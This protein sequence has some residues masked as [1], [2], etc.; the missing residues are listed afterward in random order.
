M[1]I[2]VAG[3]SG[4][5]GNAVLRQLKNNSDVTVITA[6]SNELDLTNQMM[7]EN[8]FRSNLIDQVYLC[9]AKVGGI[10]ANSKF[11]ADFI[12]NNLMIQSNVIHSAHKN[13]VQKLLF[14]GSSCIY[15]KM[16]EQPIKEEALLTGK[17]E[18]TNEPYAIAKIA[19]IKLCESFNRQFDR[20]YRCIM[21]TNLYGPGD[22][23]H[24]ENSHV[25]ASLI[26]KFHEAKENHNNEIY[27]W[28]TGKP[29]RELLYVDDLADAS[30]YIMNLEKN[31]YDSVTTSQ[32][33]HLNIGSGFEC[34]I[35]E[36]TETI[37]KVVG[38][39]GKVIWDQSMPDG[40]PRK[41]MDGSKA[42]NLGWNAKVDLMEGL[43][44]AYNSYLDTL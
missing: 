39:E 10:L 5:V 2:F 30:I 21:P 16:C 34:S 44:I 26:R 18:A 23:Y 41:I 19:G 4:M 22:N 24:P 37:A 33:R 36:L 8:F 38:F 43:N 20:D 9:A 6:S 17:L 15:P 11:P 27:A 25:V 3:H 29:K 13:N 31:I 14:L 32:N 28:G 42:S 1:N 40:T 7:V 12:Y 35:K